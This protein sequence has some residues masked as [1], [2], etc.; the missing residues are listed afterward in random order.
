MAKITFHNEPATTAGELPKVGSI[1]ANFMAVSSDLKEKSLSDYKGHRIVLSIFPSVDTGVCA[2]SVRRFNQEANNLKNTKILCISKDLPFAM[3][4]F[5]GAE[6]LKNVEVL[7]DF[8]G[9]FSSKY[10]VELLDTP[11]KGLLS[12]AIIVIDENETVIYTEQVDEITN[13][14]D[15]EA[16]LNVLK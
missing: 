7:S 3:A 9:D 13:E 1:A 11:L 16:V 6:G 8:R 15:Y 2:A 12:R 5:C 14:P 4:R 10:H